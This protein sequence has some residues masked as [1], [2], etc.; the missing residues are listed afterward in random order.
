MNEIN[1]I[2][3]GRLLQSVETLTVEITALREDM[4]TMKR[5][6][7]MLYGIMLAAG[8]I[9]AGITKVVESIIK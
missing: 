5:G 6:K 7:Y 4:E 2:Q 3:F 9:G 1:P 8:G